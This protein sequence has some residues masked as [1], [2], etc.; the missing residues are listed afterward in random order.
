M[1]RERFIRAN[2]ALIEE[3][4]RSIADKVH[5]LIPGPPVLGF[6]LL[7]DERKTVMASITVPADSAPLNA[8]VKFLDSE[9]NETPADDVPAWTSSDE[10]VASVSAG[11]DGLSAEVSVGAPGVALIE[12]K[13]VEA[14]TGAEVVAQGTITVQPGD[15]VIGE[16]SFEEGGSEEPPPVEEEVPA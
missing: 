1:F 7:S 4:L 12:V 15:A 16:V 2:A 13:S 10:A 14:N 3:W 6:I 8:S 11:D 9:G 5:E